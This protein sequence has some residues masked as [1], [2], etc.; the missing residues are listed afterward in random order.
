MQISCIYVPY[1]HIIINASF[2]I[3]ATIKI[4]MKADIVSLSEILRKA[5]YR[6]TPGKIAIIE[7]LARA[8]QPVKANDLIEKLKKE[9]DPVT[10]YRALESF[11]KSGLVKKIHFHDRSTRYE[12]L[13]DEHHHHIVC[14]ECGVLEDF[15]SCGAEQMIENIISRSKKFKVVNDHS[16]E[17]FGVCYSCSKKIHA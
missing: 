6:A 2:C 13:L 12:L 4:L 11:D 8:G 5:G 15:E 10:V 3:Y 14:T 9:V 16:F 17:L 7:A 1:S